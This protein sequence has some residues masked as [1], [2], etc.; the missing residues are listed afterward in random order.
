MKIECI[1]HLLRNYSGKILNISKDTSIPLSERR[2]LTADR[3]KRLRTAVTSAVRFRKAQNLS[4]AEQIINFKKDI[5]NSPKH[6]FGD[7]TNCEI[8]AQLTKDRKTI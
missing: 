7:H 5:L 3:Q 8:I 1:N 2:H 6:I 4:Q